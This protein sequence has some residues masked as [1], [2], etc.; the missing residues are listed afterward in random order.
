MQTDDSFEELIFLDALASY[1]DSCTQPA[2]T[3]TCPY[4][5]LVDGRPVCG[6]ECYGVLAR[7]GVT[8]RPVQSSRVGG[9]VMTGRA[10][11]LSAARGNDDF[12]A[13]QLFLQDR[14]KPVDE[15]STAALL[16][17]LRAEVSRNVFSSRA[18]AA[19]AVSVWGEL[20]R[21]GIDMDRVFI[22]GLA[23][24]MSLTVAARTVIEL[25]SRKE[26]V[27]ASEILGEGF[28][29]DRASWAAI[30]EQAVT[31]MTPDPHGWIDAKLETLVSVLRSVTGL[32][33]DVVS[34]SQLLGNPLIRY[35][36]SQAYLH[37][38]TEWLAGLLELNLEAAL[39]ADVPTPDLF[40]ALSGRE[41]QQSSGRWIWERF[42]ITSL[43]QWTSASLIQEWQWSKGSTTEVCSTRTMAERA[44]NS[45]L[46]AGAAMQSLNDDEDD[47]VFKGIEVFHPQRYVQVAS[48][49]LAVGEWDKA[50]GVFEGIVALRPGDG[51]AWNNLGFCQLGVS[52]AI[53]LPM[54]RRGAA[55]QNPIPTICIAN[56]VLALHLLGRDSEALSLAATAPRDD[57]EA[58]ATVWLHP[59]DDGEL[60]LGHSSN[61]V[62][63]LDELCSHIEQGECAMSGMDLHISDPEVDQ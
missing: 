45:D 47:S 16:I 17:G 44:T 63:Y 25:L 8:N 36:V 54:L 23:P 31:G 35:A 34:F 30:V 13:T 40:N 20:L 39:R 57:T 3:P 24:L 27:D 7:H 41:T 15:R 4:Y 37:R 58:S 11:P 53:A 28:D 29:P 55:L 1:A 33:E 56:E 5:R 18:D 51:E 42:T 50:A 14:H 9:L 38:V 61:T 46:V 19:E 48:N 22:G 2:L 10:I 49:Y 26:V 62:L 21:R 32:V 52:A 59:V 6:E 43:E 12:D 60:E